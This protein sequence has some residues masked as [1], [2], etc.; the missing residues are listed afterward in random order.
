VTDDRVLFG[1]D[2][3]SFATQPPSLIERLLEANTIGARVRLLRTHF[4]LTRREF[5]KRARIG[6]SGLDLVEND[7]I[8][9][10]LDAAA[11]MGIY[12]GFGID[13]NTMLGV[14]R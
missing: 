11:L 5:A 3:V 6:Y 1:L 10:R 9:C 4:H 2:L 12:A 13:P 14:R 7:D 8:I